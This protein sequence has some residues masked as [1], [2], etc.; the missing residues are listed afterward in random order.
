MGGGASK[1]TGKRPNK[2][3]YK[4]ILIGG[5]IGKSRLALG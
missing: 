4:V 1:Q 3:E 5:S 2:V